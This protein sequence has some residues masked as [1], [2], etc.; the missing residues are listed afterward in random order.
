VQNVH[1]I[2][3]QNR[4]LEVSGNFTTNVPLSAIGPTPSRVPAWKVPREVNSGLPR[5]NAQLTGHL[6]FCGLC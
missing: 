5:H 6:L 4:F 1:S 3:A 2:L